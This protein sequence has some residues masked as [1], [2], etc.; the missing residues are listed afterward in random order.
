M[1]CFVTYPVPNL[2][3]P[4]LEVS[5]Q[6]YEMSC[7]HQETLAVESLSDHE[8]Q[9]L[10]ICDKRTIQKYRMQVRGRKAAIPINYGIVP[11]QSIDQPSRALHINRTSDTPNVGLS[12]Y[13]MP[14][15]GTPASDV[16]ST[17]RWVG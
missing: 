8:V 13:S 9:G 16:V 3:K 14:T 12:S 11:V 6:R 4:P 2:L 10:W 7:T 15:N 5:L 17:V 1:A